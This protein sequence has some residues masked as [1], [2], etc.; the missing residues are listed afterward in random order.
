M[1]NKITWQKAGR[2]TAPGRYMFTFG[3][4]T[5]TAD[6]LAIWQQYPEAA[7]TLVKFPADLTKRTRNIISAHSNCRPSTHV[8]PDAVLPRHRPNPPPAGRPPPA[9]RPSRA[10][11]T[12]AARDVASASPSPAT[13]GDHGRSTPLV[14]TASTA[15][16]SRL[17]RSA[18]APCRRRRSRID[19]RGRASRRRLPCG[20]DQR[21][22]LAIVRQRVGRS[23]SATKPPPAICVDAAGIVAGDA[24]A[25]ARHR[26]AA[27]RSASAASHSLTRNA[28]LA[29]RIRCS[30][31]SLPRT[32]TLRPSPEIRISGCGTAQRPDHREPAARPRPTSAAACAAAPAG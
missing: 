25:R 23:A 29:V 13:A 2:V 1:V 21:R 32:A 4:L 31:P 8:A 9:S 10:A 17:R 7:F 28:S 11:A 20:H 12:G 5:V 24:V 18:S 27:A 26:P 3:W 22:A 6:D 30:R 14:L 19:H 16:P 15:N